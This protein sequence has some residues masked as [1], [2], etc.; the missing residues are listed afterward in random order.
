[1]L[2]G[3]LLVNKPIGIS[4]FDVIRKIKKIFT[5]SK[6]G[7]TGTLD[8][9]A[10]GLLILAFGK[11]S[12]LINYM[13]LEPKVYDFSICFGKQTD[14]LDSNG[15]IILTSDTIPSSVNVKDICNHFYGEQMQVPPVFSALKVKGKRAYSL[16]RKGIFPIL[17]ERKIFISE[18]SLLKYN[19]EEKTATY[20]VACSGGTYVRALARDIAYKLKSVGYVTHLKRISCGNFSLDNAITLECINISTPLITIQQALP[21]IDMVDIDEIIFNK[22]SKGMDIS[23]DLNFQK[24]F[25]RYKNEIVALGEKKNEKRYHPSIVFG[26]G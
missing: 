5:N 25:L 12:R 8:V 16:A 1:M 21:H 17:R 20:R 14:T 3:F 19:I 4:S 11:A 9:E 23:L 18:L 10:E 26:I 7:H 24:I 22:I 13:Y 6:I 2:N 15:K